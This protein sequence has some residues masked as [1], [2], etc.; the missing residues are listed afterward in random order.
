M[1]RICSGT[2]TRK[3][4]KRCSRRAREVPSGTT[5]IGLT[6]EHYG[7]HGTPDPGHIRHDESAGCVRLTN[8][9][10]D[11]L[12]HMVRPGTPVVLEQ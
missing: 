10:V 8:W 3:K 4:R 12:S 1:T 6:K 5:W 7:I 9:D 2:R 11:D